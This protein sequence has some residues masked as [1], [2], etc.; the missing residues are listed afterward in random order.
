MERLVRQ[1]GAMDRGGGILN[2]EVAV[3][4]L[5]GSNCEAETARAVRHCGG[6]A[7]IVR[8]N[9]PRE[10]LVEY[11]GYI[12]PGGVSYQDRIRRGARWARTPVEGSSLE[13]GT[14]AR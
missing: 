1:V 11:S 2:G 3:L 6:R 12:I 7:E 10:R 14:R 4:Q 9:V 5:P 13:G 8:W